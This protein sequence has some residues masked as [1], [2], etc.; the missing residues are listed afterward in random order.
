VLCNLASG[1]R[2]NI[3]YVGRGDRAL[4]VDVGVSAKK[5]AEKLVERGLDPARVAGIVLTHEHGDH[6]RGA[7][8]FARR[9]QVPIY[10]QREA[11]AKVPLDGVPDVRTFDG[12]RPFEVAGF[13][14][15]PFSI[16]HDTVEPVAFVIDDGCQRVGIATDMGMTTHLTVEKL[17]T[18]QAVVLEF[19]H[20]L[21]MLME[22]PY[23]WWLKQRVRGRLGHLDNTVALDVLERIV[24][25]GVQAALLGHLSQ[26]NNDPSLVRALALERLAHNGQ[27]HV[28]LTVLDQDTPGPVVRVGEDSR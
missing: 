23:P 15:H 8:V 11:R 10:V 20:D 2:G 13:E 9:H 21:K 27:E 5:A 26:E 19:N 22:G 17:R 16:P 14:V 12:D 4:L 18:C 25:G 7:R 24:D 6:A 3:T 1:S 28:Q